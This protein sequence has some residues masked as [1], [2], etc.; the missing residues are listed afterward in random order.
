MCP[1][2]ISSWHDIL[3]KAR[4]SPCSNIN[5]SPAACPAVLFL[6][7]WKANKLQDIVSSQGDGNTHKRYKYFAVYYILNQIISFTISIIKHWLENLYR[8]RT[9]EAAIIFKPRQLW[10]VT[11]NLKKN[12]FPKK[13]DI[14]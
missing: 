8:T 9:K 14:L 11:R 13:K 4:K 12:C 6:Y 2:D 3:P 5:I 7:S 10:N 1:F